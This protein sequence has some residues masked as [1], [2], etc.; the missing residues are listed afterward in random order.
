VEG[1]HA[2]AVAS[3][4]PI[5]HHL[6]EFG[7]S[8][9]Q[10]DVL[11]RT[12]LESA[13]RAGRLDIARALAAERL[14]VKPDSPYNWRQEARVARAAGDEARAEEAERRASALRRPPRAS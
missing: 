10:R 4:Y 9:A 12:L 7:G 5:R 6:N 14:L 3:L 2:D 11:Q 13:L 8:H 1:R